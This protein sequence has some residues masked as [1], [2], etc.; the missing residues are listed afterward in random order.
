VKTLLKTC[1][2]AL[3]AVQGAFA[4]ELF[5]FRYGRPKILM[6]A[7]RAGVK[8]FSRNRSPV[9]IRM[10]LERFKER[11]SQDSHFRNKKGKHYKRFR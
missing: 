6:Q 10:A 8:E 3:T 1:Q 7:M 11:Q 5:W 9:E 4:D 2:Q